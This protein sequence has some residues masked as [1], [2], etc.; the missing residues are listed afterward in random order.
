M[1]LGEFV[2]TSCLCF[3]N[4]IYGKNQDFN[5]YTKT[6]KEQ[7]QVSQALSYKKNIGSIM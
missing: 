2:L 6:I 4:I 3:M 5:L 7:L 1:F